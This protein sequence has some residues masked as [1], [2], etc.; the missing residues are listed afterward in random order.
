VYFKLDSS[1]L[2]IAILEKGYKAG[3]LNRV[4]ELVDTT[5]LDRYLSDNRDKINPDKVL[6]DI[7]ANLPFESFNSLLNVLRKH[8]LYRFR[9]VTRK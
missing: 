6:L 1:F 8:E 7:P 5:A 3:L 2:N 4:T 9:M